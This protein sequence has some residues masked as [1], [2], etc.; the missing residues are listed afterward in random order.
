MDAFCLFA[1]LLMADRR[2]AWIC[3]DLL[4]LFATRVI[5]EMLRTAITRIHERAGNPKPTKCILSHMLT[6][7][8]IPSFVCLT[9]RLDHRLSSAICSDIG[10]Y[11]AISVQYLIRALRFCTVQNLQKIGC[12]SHDALWLQCVGMPEM[13]CH[14]YLCRNMASSQT[15][16]AEVR[17]TRST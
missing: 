14:V 17:R 12:Q 11:P 3:I 5:A 7:Y 8:P 13:A 16:P 15:I 9:K 10:R 4:D 1:V 6:S 2:C